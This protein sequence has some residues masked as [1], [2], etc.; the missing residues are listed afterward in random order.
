ME[1]YPIYSNNRFYIFNSG[2]RIYCDTLRK[3][4]KIVSLRDDTYERKERLKNP[5]HPFYYHVQFDD[6]SFDTYISSND[7]TRI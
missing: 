5:N 2:D 6:G 4:G 1:I 7:L 3:Y